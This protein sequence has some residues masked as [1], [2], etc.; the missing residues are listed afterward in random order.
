MFTTMMMPK[1]TGSIPSLSPPGTGSG[2]DQ[3]DGRGL[4]EVAGQQQQH[5]DREQEG[6]D[7]QP[8]AEHP[9]A[10]ACGMFSLV[11]MKLNSTALVMM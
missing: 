8:V 5:I 10:S 7:A 1:C 11:M 4:H 9:F 3:H 2:E 6:D